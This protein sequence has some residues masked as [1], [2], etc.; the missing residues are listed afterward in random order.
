MT[1]APPSFGEVILAVIAVALGCLGAAAAVRTAWVSGNWFAYVC[2]LGCTAFVAG[3][4]GQRVFPSADAVQR[5]GATAAA[6]SAPGPWDA[7]ISLPLV[8]IRMTPVALAG[9]LVAAVGLSLVLLFERAPG[10]GRQPRVL[11]PLEQDD[12]V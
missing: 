2:A 5:L 9:L 1:P 10:S 11:P 4:A 7:G 8:P 3:I 6:T 12:A